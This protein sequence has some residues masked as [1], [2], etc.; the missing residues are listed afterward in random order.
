[1][2]YVF[3]GV[4]RIIHLT[5][6]VSELDLKDLYS[7]WKDWVHSGEGAK[8]YH[9]FETV[10]GDPVDVERGIYITSYF[11]LVNGWRIKPRETDHRLRVYNGVILTR[12]GDSPFVF[13]SGGYNVLVEYSQPVKT[14]SVV[15]EV[16]V[17]GLTSQES[18]MLE[19]VYQRVGFLVS[20]MKGKKYLEKKGDKWYLVVKDERRGIELLRKEL[21]DI[22]GK[23][24]EDVPRGVIAIE[25]ESEV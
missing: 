23:P 17:S 24:I 6:E 8:F 4:N 11:F 10:G 20:L 25:E 14:E 19:A 7:R 1:M 2:K 3:D 12:E 18:E 16:G 15:I 13:T 22:E 9:A 21:K 5:E